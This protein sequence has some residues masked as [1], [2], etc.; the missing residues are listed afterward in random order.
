MEV[1][2][3]FACSQKHR[4]QL[5][6]M[7]LIPV[8]QVGGQPESLSLLSLMMC[9][10]QSLSLEAKS[11]CSTSVVC[12][13]MTQSCSEKQTGPAPKCQAVCD[14]TLQQHLNKYVIIQCTCNGKLSLTTFAYILSDSCTKGILLIL[15]TPTIDTIASD[16]IM[17][18]KE[19]KFS[20]ISQIHN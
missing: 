2:C 15:A 12:T 1:R 3:T 11:V 16:R 9:I 19:L 14:Y 6:M 10:S 18:W 13:S 5:L 20:I 7:P 17:W 8:T 4:T